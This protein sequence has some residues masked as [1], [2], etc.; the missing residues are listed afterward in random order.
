M[1]KPSD[2]VSAPASLVR[3][4]SKGI[5]LLFG[6]LLILTVYGLAESINMLYAGRPASL[7][8][9]IIFSLLAADAF[10]LLITVHE[11]TSENPGL[12]RYIDVWILGLIPYFGWLFVYWLGKRI[13]DII[14]RNRG[15]VLVISLILYVGIIVL[16]LCVYLSVSSPPGTNLP[17]QY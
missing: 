10:I 1:S 6:I 14:Q 2:S 16:C 7:I 8:E 5:S 12:L 3:D 13:A 4:P 9:L 17:A 11:R 15:N